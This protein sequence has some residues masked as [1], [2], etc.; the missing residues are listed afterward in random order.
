[1]Y[2]VHTKFSSGIKTLRHEK[3]KGGMINKVN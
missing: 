1:M 2:K 3:L